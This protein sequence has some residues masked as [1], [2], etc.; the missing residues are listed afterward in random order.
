MERSMARICIPH[1]EDLEGPQK[2]TEFKAQN[3]SIL[4]EVFVY[5]RENHVSVFTVCPSICAEN[6]LSQERLNTH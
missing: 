3:G 4:E 6:T 5:S 1:N 2:S